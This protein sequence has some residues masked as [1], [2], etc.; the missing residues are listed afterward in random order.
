MNVEKGLKE[1]FV[2]LW[3]WKK[4]CEKE[5]DYECEKK[6]YS[7]YILFLFYFILLTVTNCCH[8]SLPIYHGDGVNFFWSAMLRILPSQIPF[9]RSRIPT[10]T[11]TEVLARRKKLSVYA[12]TNLREQVLDCSRHSWVLWCQTQ[13]FMRVALCFYRVINGV[14]VDLF[15]RT[16]VI[17]TIGSRIIQWECLREAQA[18]CPPGKSI[19]ASIAIF[20][21]GKSRAPRSSISADHSRA[22]ESED[23]WYA[24]RAGRWAANAFQKSQ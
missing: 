5:F 2:L 23:C 8:R 22:N 1:N 12:W 15:D 16:T 3:M 21:A 6:F 10:L 17:E 14:S 4:V 11:A 24:R 7:N 19:D 20:P 13:D 18:L 9:C